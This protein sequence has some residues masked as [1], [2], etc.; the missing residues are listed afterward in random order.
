MPTN[1]NPTTWWC[2]NRH[3]ARKRIF[4]RAGEARD[5]LGDVHAQP[6][7]FVRS[8]GLFFLSWA[9]PTRGRKK[10][11]CVAVDTENTA[12]NPKKRLFGKK[13]RGTGIKK[14]GWR[15][16]TATTGASSRS[17]MPAWTPPC[18]PRA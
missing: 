2:D 9:A 13:R 12:I 1:H 17:A 15:Q 4:R 16:A 11:W 5:G 3:H 10:Y 7:F 14:E 18:V 6:L 8:R